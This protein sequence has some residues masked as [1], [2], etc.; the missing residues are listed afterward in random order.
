[1][2]TRDKMLEAKAKAHGIRL[3]IKEQPPEVLY[4]LGNS[5]TLDDEGHFQHEQLDECVDEWFEE[6]GYEKPLQKAKIYTWMSLPDI[7]ITVSCIDRP[8]DG[9]GMHEHDWEFVK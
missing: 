5:F 9:E 2:T 7:N 8:E 3:M 1:M 6:N 4:Y